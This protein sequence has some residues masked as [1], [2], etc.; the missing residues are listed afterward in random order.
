MLGKAVSCIVLG[1][2]LGCIRRFL[3]LE[4]FLSR[5]KEPTQPVLGLLLIVL[6]GSICPCFSLCEG[7]FALLK[8]VHQ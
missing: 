5:D 3:G 6:S 4:H 7:P 8:H 2:L 1:P